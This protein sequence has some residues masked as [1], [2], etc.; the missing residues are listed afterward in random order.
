MIWSV[1][2]IGTIGYHLKSTT[3]TPAIDGE[4]FTLPDIPGYPILNTQL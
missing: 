1:P 4:A 3:K 2:T